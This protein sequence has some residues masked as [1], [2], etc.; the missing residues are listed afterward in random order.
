[1]AKKIDNKNLVLFEL[2]KLENK[3]NEFQSYLELNPINA[4]VT[5]GNEIILTEENQDKLH[6][7]IVIQIKMQDALFSWI[8]LLEKLREGEQNKELETRGDIEV[9]GLFKSNISRG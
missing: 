8:P 5:R 2:N 9:N 4:S 6:K 7:E 1:M 3:V